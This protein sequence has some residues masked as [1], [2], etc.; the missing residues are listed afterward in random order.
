[1]EQTIIDLLSQ[2]KYQSSNNITKA[3][4][5]NR[6]YINWYMNKNKKFSRV[7]PL[8]VGSMKKTLRVWKITQQQE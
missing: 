6:K 2:K 5:M 8:E 4:G 3:T 7:D 1:M